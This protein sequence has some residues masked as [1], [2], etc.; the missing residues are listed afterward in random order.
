MCVVCGCLRVRMLGSPILDSANSV[1][2]KACM[3]ADLLTAMNWCMSVAAKVGI[4]KWGWLSIFNCGCGIMM[5][6]EHVY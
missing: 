1:A 3:H 4:L 6:C 2:M 5:M